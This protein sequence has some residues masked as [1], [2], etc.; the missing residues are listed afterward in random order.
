MSR[1]AGGAHA[2]AFAGRLIAI[3]LLLCASAPY[4][5][6]ARQATPAATPTG[7]QCDVAPLSPA[8]LIAQL[9]T[10]PSFAGTLQTPR[11]V[12][13]GTPADAA[14]TAAITSVVRQLEACINSGDQLRVYALFSD[15]LFRQPLN[16]DLVADLTTELAEL[17]HATPT[18]IPS[19]ERQILTGPWHVEMLDDGRVMAAVVFGFEDGADYPSSTKALFFV[20]QGGRWLIEEIVDTLWLEGG[21]GP[22]SVEDV[23]GR[24]PS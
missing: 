22:V 24:P 20:R 23:V 9:E 4:T 16:P 19:G 7:G 10:A 1:R 6:H 13:P 8:A 17:A 2:G 5:A 18:P 15:D 11:R 21:A 3:V 12:P 14:T